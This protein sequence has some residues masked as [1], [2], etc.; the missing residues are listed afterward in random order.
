MRIKCY[1]LEVLLK[2]HRQ[3][4]RR[5]KQFKL[6]KNMEILLSKLIY[7]RKKN[8]W[9]LV[10]KKVLLM[11]FKKCKYLLMQM[12]NSKFKIKYSIKN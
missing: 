11:Y 8:S 3:I 6:I 12:K 9:K 4:V 10:W 7:V 1:R 2:I 5:G